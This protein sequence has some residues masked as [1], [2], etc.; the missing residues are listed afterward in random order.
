[1]SRLVR[2][3]SID[4]SLSVCSFR[5][6]TRLPQQ[7]HCVTV[8][9]ALPIL[10]LSL[11]FARSLVSTSFCILAQ[12]LNRSASRPTLSHSDMAS[13]QSTTTPSTFKA[14]SDSP[15][16]P[17]PL[18]MALETHGNDST[19]GAPETPRAT[20]TSSSSL[21]P[22]DCRTLNKL[23]N[24]VWTPSSLAS[25]AV[26]DL[27]EPSTST[28]E[29]DVS[30]AG[31]EDTVH[32]TEPLLE[33]GDERE[34]GY[35]D[36]DESM[37]LSIEQVTT[38]D[39]DASTLSL[40]DSAYVWSDGDTVED[41]MNTPGK[42]IPP[43]PEL[44]LSGLN[45]RPEN[46]EI[47]ARRAE[48]EKEVKQERL[49]QEQAEAG[50]EDDGFGPDADSYDED[51]A[52]VLSDDPDFKAIEAIHATVYDKEDA[53]VELEACLP[54]PSENEQA[55]NTSQPFAPEDRRSS[56]LFSPKPPT[57]HSQIDSLATS[58]LNFADVR[59]SVT[60]T[61]SG[62]HLAFTD[63][64]T[65]SESPFYNN[66]ALRSLKHYRGK[67]NSPSKSRR[68]ASLPEE[69]AELAR[70]ANE[71]DD[72][73][74][75]RKYRDLD[76]APMEPEE[77]GGSTFLESPEKRSRALSMGS[78]IDE[79]LAE[80][81]YD[82]R[83]LTPQS[84]G[85]P[86]REEFVS[87]E[88]DA[89]THSEEVFDLGTLTPPSERTEFAPLVLP[90]RDHAREDDQLILYR[91]DPTFVTVVSMLPEAMFWAAAAPVAKLGNLAYDKLAEQF[92]GSTVDEDGGSE[93]K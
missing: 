52:V 58:S 54:L 73:K 32:Y 86:T 36:E 57:R 10:S 2:A 31:L 25:P 33:P 74:D 43:A 12:P 26:S 82:L 39:T 6:Q 1:M 68:N 34:D 42:K 92:T 14:K 66:A 78:K 50:A 77:D 49:D 83:T 11:H 24:D 5:A 67:E 17:I 37:D 41:V 60:A 79:E 45:V 16:Q 20:T 72:D 38:T 63:I 76:L 46:E 91:E 47:A 89:D 8:P 75:L 81:V 80:E 13:E 9:I 61:T 19:L 64:A 40:D 55:A 84:D 88:Q 21:S 30:D 29:D 28:A 22:A 4:I 85:S 53:I 56:R 90:N 71:A 23:L 15:L 69:I 44:D 18:R 93:E 59:P 65:I 70:E 51:D 87:M 3:W 62:K 7:Q 48:I 35:A 27:S